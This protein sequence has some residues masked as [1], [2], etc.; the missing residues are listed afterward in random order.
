MHGMA[1]F[2]EQSRIITEYTEIR[3]ADAASKLPFIIGNTMLLIL[4]ASPGKDEAK[5]LLRKLP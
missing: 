2:V 1:I 3:K 5:K 4:P